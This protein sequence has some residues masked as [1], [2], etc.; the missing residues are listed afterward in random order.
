MQ[1]D[2]NFMQGR[3]VANHLMHPLALQNSRG[4][5]H[6][7]ASHYQKPH[8]GVCYRDHAVNIG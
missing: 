5:G 6:N 4:V 1:F 2:F 8:A 7:P 3:R